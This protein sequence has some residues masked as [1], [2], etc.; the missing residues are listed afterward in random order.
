MGINQN[1]IKTIGCPPI[2]SG[3]WPILICLAHCHWNSID[4]PLFGHYGI[5]H[6]KVWC[7]KLIMKLICIC[8]SI[9]ETLF[10]RWHAC[11]LM[12]THWRVFVCGVNIWNM[13]ALPN[14]YVYLICGHCNLCNWSYFAFLL[15]VRMH[16][17]LFIIC[18]VQVCSILMIICVLI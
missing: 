3:P 5:G 4:W 17:I 1:I 15:S 9:I 11:F 2:L 6:L 7:K 14:N 10:T 16:R 8:R 18:V 12:G 13:C